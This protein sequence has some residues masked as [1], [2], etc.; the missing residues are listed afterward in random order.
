MSKQPGW[1]C[2]ALGS[3]DAAIPDAAYE[4]KPRMIVIVY[5]GSAHFWDTVLCPSLNGVGVLHKN[6]AEMLR[7]KKWKCEK[8][9]LLLKVTRRGD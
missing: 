1:P 8:A 7:F 2:K 4:L 5:D 6:V 3:Y 9:G